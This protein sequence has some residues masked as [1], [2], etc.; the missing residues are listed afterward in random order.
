MSEIIAVL[1]YFPLGAVAGPAIPLTLPDLDAIAAKY[2]V[3]LQLQ[4]VQG[5]NT[6]VDG[7]G[8]REE[9]MN[10]AI[11]EITQS[12]ITMSAKNE[13]TGEKALREIIRKYR[14]PRTVFGC[15]GSNEKGKS[16]I[17]RICDEDDGWR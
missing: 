12:V 4:E 11:E 17:A 1:R 10:C 3:S 9:T 7:I 2:G 8:L 15:W 5:K 13:S 6:L 14:A 16:V